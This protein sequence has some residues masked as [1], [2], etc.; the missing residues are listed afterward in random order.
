MNELYRRL[1]I[2]ISILLRNIKLQD[3][4]TQFPFDYHP[5]PE[6]NSL[7]ASSYWVSSVRNGSRVGIQNIR[8]VITL[9]GCDSKIR[10]LGT[11]RSQIENIS[12]TGSV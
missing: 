3:S 8:K 6:M 10:N 7:F 2:K 11:S 4:I 12:M 1:A 5:R 9:E